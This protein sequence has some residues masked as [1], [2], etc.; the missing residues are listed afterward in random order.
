MTVKYIVK[1]RDCS[2]V[3]FFHASIMR[4]IHILTL[5]AGSFL[6]GE[7]VSETKQIQFIR[8]QADLRMI[9]KKHSVEEEARR[10][11][12]DVMRSHAQ[13]DRRED[14][15][16]TPKKMVLQVYG[17]ATVSGK[18]TDEDQNPISDVEVRADFEDGGTWTKTGSDGTYEM[19]VNAGRVW[20][21]VNIN[22]LVP[23]YLQPRDQEDEVVNG[24]KAMVNFT[25]YSTD[26]AISGMILL[27]GAA[28]PGVY[29]SADGR[30]GYTWTETGANGIFTLNVASDADAS[31]GYNLRVNTHDF[32]K[33]AFRT[34]RYDGITSG[35][36]DLTINLVSATSS[37]E[38]TVTD[39]SGMAVGDVTVFANQHQRQNLDKSTRRFDGTDQSMRS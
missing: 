23:D 8:R 1:K 33:S 16:A 3:N 27:D 34:E 25:A 5:F 36:S 13:K 30:L 28:L 15:H 26:A 22:D 12:S 17:S 18:L 32:A 29:V 19:I 21:R 24:A 9:E 6:L 7:T 4:P 2:D 37:I 11:H 38:G 39:N 20:I 35:T 10:I 31:G 14:V